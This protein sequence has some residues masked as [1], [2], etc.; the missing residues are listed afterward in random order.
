MG[1]QIPELRSKSLLKTY[2]FS[3]LSYILNEVFAD[4]TAFKTADLL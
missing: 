4:P 3:R 1:R 2:V